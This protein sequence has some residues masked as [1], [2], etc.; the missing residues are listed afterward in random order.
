MSTSTA[1]TQS[2]AIETDSQTR[3]SEKQSRIVR[4]LENKVEDGKVF[5][6]SKFMSDELGM[7]A[8][9]IGANMLRLSE[10]YEDLKIEKWS[11]ASATTW[12]VEKSQ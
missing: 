11:Y 1:T 12:R 3:M 5:F 8:K 4:Y 10:E 6:K 9:E 2:Q 7:S